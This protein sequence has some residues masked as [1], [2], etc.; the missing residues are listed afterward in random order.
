MMAPPRSRWRS[1]VPDAMPARRTGTE[2]VSECDAGV[3]GEPDADADERVAEADLP[4]RAA[5]LPEQQHGEEAEQAEH[6]AGE[7]R[8]PRSPGLDELRRAGRDEHH[9]HRGRQ[10]GEPGVERG[11]AEHVLQELLADEH[12]AHQRAEHD[13]PGAR[14]PPR[15]CAARRRAR[16]YSGT[17]ARRWRM[18]KATPAPRPRSLPSPSASRPSSGT[19]AKLMARTSAATSRTDRMPP[20]LSTGSVVSFTWPGTKRDGQHERHRGQRQRDQEHRAPPEVLEQRSRRSAARAR[21]C[22]PPIATTA[23]STGSRPAR[24]QRGDQRQRRGVGH[25]G[26]DAAEEAGE[27]RAPRRSAP[28]A[29]SRQ[30]GTDSA[31]PRIEHQLAAVPV[32]ERAEPEHRRGQAEGVADRDQVERR[33]ATSRTPCRCRAGRRWRPPGSGWRPRRRGSARGARPLA[34]PERRDP[35]WCPR[36]ARGVPGQRPCSSSG[37]PGPDEPEP[38]N[39]PALRITRG[40]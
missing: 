38:S 14:P 5:L 1:A 12:R 32:A 2:P 33:S 26:G 40:G 6:V 27:R 30:A 24:P 13:D 34:A 37:P 9:E 10:D 17:G 31:T 28:S 7:Q 21:R 25:A 39:S 20:R 3:P 36:Q 19:G 29:A 8:E 23:R 11:V 22:A 4:V 16:S 35:G 18:T 15:R